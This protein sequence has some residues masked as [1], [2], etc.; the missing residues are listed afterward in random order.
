MPCRHW[1]W[2]LVVTEHVKVGVV[3]VA[4]TCGSA[5]STRV[6]LSVVVRSFNLIENGVASDASSNN[7]VLDLALHLTRL[8]FTFMG[9]LLA[10]HMRPFSLT[11]HKG[12]FDHQA[13]R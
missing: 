7:N 10:S 3:G 6:I 8:H 4:H 13:A 2:A 12:S 9:L 1:Q 11:G 5:L